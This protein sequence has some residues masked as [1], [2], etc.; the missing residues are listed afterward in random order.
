ME[1][2]LFYQVISFNYDTALDE[3]FFWHFTKS[4]EY[5]GLDLAGVNGH[6]VGPGVKADVIFIKP[7]GSLNLLRCNKCARAHLQWFRRYLP[8]GVGQQSADNRRCVHCTEAL[9][10][11]PELMGQFVVP[12]LYDKKA[13]AQSKAA[14]RNAF[15]WAENVVAIGFSFPSQDAYF[16]KCMTDGL[17][18]N[19]S[20]L[21]TLYIVGQNKNG[22][23]LTKQQL[24]RNSLLQPFKKMLKV[25]AVDAGGFEGVQIGGRDIMA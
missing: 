11:R 8:T 4:W 1:F 23:K 17:K 18:R 25:I 2:N 20:R 5:G 19:K 9:P 21:V 16:L 6:P 13:I 12:P 7:H 14:I 15:S 3:A 24:L 22:A 10:G